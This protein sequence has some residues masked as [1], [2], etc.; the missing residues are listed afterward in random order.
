[1]SCTMCTAE[2]TLLLSGSVHLLTRA[3][4]KV[5]INLLWKASVLRHYG[6]YV[7][8]PE[9]SYSANFQDGSNISIFIL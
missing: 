3:G 2:L 9:Q 8:F 1:M 4:D 6:F 7:A 5:A